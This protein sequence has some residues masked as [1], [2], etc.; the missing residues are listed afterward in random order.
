MNINTWEEM[1][2]LDNCDYG[3]LLNSRKKSTRHNHYVHCAA[4]HKS[5]FGGELIPSNFTYYFPH[6][7]KHREL[8]SKWVGER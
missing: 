2:E 1:I 5:T 8:V 6:T 7:S 4:K 3:N